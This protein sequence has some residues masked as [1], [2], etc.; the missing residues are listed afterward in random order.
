MNKIPYGQSFTLLTPLLG[1]ECWNYSSDVTADLPVGI[2][3]KL[4]N[5]NSAVATVITVGKEHQPI[6]CSNGLSGYRFIVPNVAL[7]EATG[8]ELPEVV[9]DVVGDIMRFEA[10]E[11]GEDEIRPFLQG[12]YDDGILPT[13]QGSYHRAHQRYCTNFKE[14]ECP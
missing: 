12:L 10:G 9:R 14:E 5:A 6:A 8:Q 3:V 1:V 4:D 7:G 11:M 13:L 2:S